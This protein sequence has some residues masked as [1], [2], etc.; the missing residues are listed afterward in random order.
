MNNQFSNVKFN[1]YVTFHEK[2]KNDELRKT[3]T[4]MVPTGLKIKK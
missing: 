1:K 2:H 3:G 4:I